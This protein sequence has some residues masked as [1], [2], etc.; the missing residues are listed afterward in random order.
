[1]RLDILRSGTS[2]TGSAPRLAEDVAFYSLTALM[3]SVLLASD[4]VPI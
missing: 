4:L 2:N 1:M 3:R